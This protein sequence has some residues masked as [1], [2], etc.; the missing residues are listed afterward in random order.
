MRFLARWQEQKHLPPWES[1]FANCSWAGT[2]EVDMGTSDNLGARE[3]V[4]E[5]ECGE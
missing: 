1:V 5:G 4:N 3:H 2:M